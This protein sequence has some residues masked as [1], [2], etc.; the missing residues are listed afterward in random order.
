MLFRSYSGVFVDGDLVAQSNSTKH[1]TQST[2]TLGIGARSDGSQP[3]KGYISNVRV[4]KGDFLY[5]VDLS[6]P[7]EAIYG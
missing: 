1:P 4:V 5:N 2:S 6:A 7:S 3:F